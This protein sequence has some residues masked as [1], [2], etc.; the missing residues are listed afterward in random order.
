MIDAGLATYLFEIFPEAF[1]ITK[2][3]KT[4]ETV[5]GRSG[6]EE[7]ETR[8]HTGTLAECI[9]STA[10]SISHCGNYMEDAYRYLDG[11][12]PKMI[13]RREIQNYLRA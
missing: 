1:S 12:K 3:C 13:Q 4:Y 10:Q 5:N 6:T 8:T 11:F 7:V 2:T 9:L